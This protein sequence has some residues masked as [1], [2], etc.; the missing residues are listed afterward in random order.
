VSQIGSGVIV[1]T[2]P[3][4]AGS[5]GSALVN[6]AGQV[7]GMTTLGPSS[8]PTPGVAVPSNQVNAVVQQLLAGRPSPTAPS[9]KAVLGVNVTDAPGGGATIQSLVAGGPAASAGIQTGWTIVS[10]GGHPVTNTGALA[11]IL[12]TYTPGQRVPVTVRL[13]DGSTRSLQVVLGSG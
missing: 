6:I 3:M 11:Q 5:S 12:A 2:A 13:P 9:A 8:A 4:S 7:I 10:V 1:T